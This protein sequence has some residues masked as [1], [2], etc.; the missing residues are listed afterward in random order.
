MTFFTQ[1]NATAWLLICIMLCELVLLALLI[2]SFF[3]S[4]AVR[5]QART[6]DAALMQRQIAKL[7]RVASQTDTP[8]TGNCNQGRNCN[9]AFTSSPLGQI[10][11]QASAAAHHDFLQPPSVLITPN[12]YPVGSEERLAWYSAYGRT[13]R[14]TINIA[15]AKS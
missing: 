7:Q 2:N 4:N 15:R 12:P 13:M 10:H 9:C 5:P 6:Y 3:K 8:C 14:T 1:L 11:L